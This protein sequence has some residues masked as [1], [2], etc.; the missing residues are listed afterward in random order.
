MFEE[1]DGL[2]M[3][4]FNRHEAALDKRPESMDPVDVPVRRPADPMY[5]PPLS[6]DQIQ[7]IIQ[8]SGGGFVSDGRLFGVRESPPT[9]RNFWYR[10]KL[11][12]RIL[13]NKT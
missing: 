10:A 3:V 4:E 7:R 6:A 1:G 12:W 11:A 2:A 8:K 9:S 13:T 5:S